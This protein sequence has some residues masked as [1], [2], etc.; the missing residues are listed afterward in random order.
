MTKF[1]HEVVMVVD[2]K[3]KKD[4][5]IKDLGLV[6]YKL[7][8]DNCTDDIFKNTDQ[9]IKTY[10]TPDINILPNDGA[11]DYT[12]KIT[13]YN[14]ELFLAIAAMSIEKWGVPGEYWKYTGNS[15]DQFTKNKIYKSVK[16]IDSTL[17]FINN[18]E[19]RDGFH[20]ENNVYMV[21]ASLSEVA[22]HFGYMIIIEG[23]RSKLIK[24]RET[25]EDRKEVK[26]PFLMLAEGCSILKNTDSK[27]LQYIESNVN[28]ITLTT[29]DDVVK[30]V[31][32]RVC[33]EWQDKIW[34][35]YSDL[36]KN[37][38]PTRVSFRNDK[39]KT[40][41]PYSD[42][43][44]TETGFHSDFKNKYP[45][46]D[47]AYAIQALN[48]LVWLRV[49]WLEAAGYSRDWKASD[50]DYKGNHWF[51]NGYGEAIESSLNNKDY[52][53]FMT[54]PTEEMCRKFMET[55]KEEIKLTRCIL[56]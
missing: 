46:K 8:R 50:N 27:L 32:D 5:L 40:Y 4:T 33:P 51:L 55:F 17:A 31:Y 44:L 6:G 7:H 43:V 15:I 12:V 47:L 18:M 52:S 23:K 49:M 3:N 35:Q 9:I 30:E 41:V 2:H 56:G 1:Q 10:T 54:F 16:S 39:F 37:K 14:P 22:K 48:K 21:K 24:R 20:P 19:A 45:T 38:Y 11:F 34:N 26:V 28:P 29:T 13:D 36:F 42:H 25:M 53:H